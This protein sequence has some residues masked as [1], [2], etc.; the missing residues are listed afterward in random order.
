MDKHSLAV[1]GG[2]FS[3]KLLFAILSSILILVASKI[4]PVQG[5]GEVVVGLVSIC[6]IYL[7]ANSAVKWQ[8]G[9][10]EKMKAGLPGA[11]GQMVDKAVEVADK[12]EEEGGA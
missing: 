1:D 3:R 7:G 6:G 9:S 12:R 5:L 11:L 8:A 4:C 2:F 10:I